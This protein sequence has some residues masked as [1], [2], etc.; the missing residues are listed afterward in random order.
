MIKTRNRLT[1]FLAIILIVELGVLCFV[2]VHKLRV[3][4]KIWVKK[5]KLDDPIIQEL[6]QEITDEDIEYYA[7][8]EHDINSL[9]AAYIFSKA[10]S[11]M[12][13]EDFSIENKMFYM[14]Y[15]ALDGGIKVG[16]G[17]DFK[18][19]LSSI[20]GTVST[21][22]EIDEKPVNFNV[23]YDS[24]KE[25]Y[26]GTYIYKDL[27]DK[28]LIKKK[29]VQA[30]RDRE[31]DINLSIDYAFYKKD[32]KYKVCEDYKCEKIIKEVDNVDDIDTTSNMTVI[33]DKASDDLYYYVGNK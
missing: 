18:Y 28:V 27:S 30:T 20:N 21:Y 15:D 32:N 25:E 9:T 11:N 6:Y 10:T 5:I 17:P 29:L 31:H 12:T 3:S 33:Y 26:V 4:N 7:E 2:I 22:F 1:P 19:D 14:S 24:T 8:G 16:F 23:K 13:S